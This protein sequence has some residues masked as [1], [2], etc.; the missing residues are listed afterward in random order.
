[1]Q[2]PA[3]TSHNLTYARAR[4][5]ERREEREKERECVSESSATENKKSQTT[6]P[7]PLRRGVRMRSTSIAPL[8]LLLLHSA[9]T[10]THTHRAVKRSGGEDERLSWVCRAW[11]ARRPFQSVN[12]LGVVSESVPWLVAPQGPDLRGVVVGARRQQRPG[13]IPR[14]CVH[15]IRMALERRDR[16]RLAEAA[17]VYR[18]IRTVWL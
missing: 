13:W 12:L 1:M 5:R 15:F 17:D 9:H 10:H 11:A 16:G 3:S 2:R 14:D 8:L 18:L 7:P 4:E 6:T